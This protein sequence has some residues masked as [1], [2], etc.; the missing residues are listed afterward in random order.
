M[1]A[2]AARV[3]AIGQK[4]RGVPKIAKRGGR[5]GSAFPNFGI[6]GRRRARRSPAHA[7]LG[8]FLR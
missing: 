6:R 4:S 7:S 3:F 5:A 8:W 2:E 1:R